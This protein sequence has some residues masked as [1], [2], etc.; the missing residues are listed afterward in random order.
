MCEDKR[1]DK[2]RASRSG[3]SFSYVFF[4]DDLML[5]AKANYKNYEAIIDVL[6]NFCNL[7]GQKVNLSKS[8]ILFS[9]NVNR[10]TKRG[11]CRS[12]EMVAT[13][14]LGKY[15]GFPIITHDRVGN[16]YNFIVNKI[17]NKL[18]GWKLKLL[19]KAGK[20]VLANTSAAPVA[21]YCMQCQSLPVKVC[22]QVDKLIRDFLWSS[23][24]ERRKLHLVN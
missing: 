24:K 21:E 14:N 18:T 11:I 12:M 4:A 19:S 15:L 7:A 5:F 2:V 9:L 17:Q 22:D 20:L 8:K 1:W 23:T 13:S 16:A 10:R 6:D 3:L